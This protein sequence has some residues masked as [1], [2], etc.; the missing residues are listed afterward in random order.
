MIVFA[1]LFVVLIIRVGYLQFIRGNELRNASLSRRL[2]TQELSANRG[3]ILDTKGTVIVGNRKSYNV[4][5]VPAEYQESDDTNVENDSKKIAELTGADQ[6]KVKESLL[7]ENSYYRLI[8]KDVAKDK[9]ELLKNEGIPGIGVEIGTV[10]NYTQGSLLANVLGFVGNDNVGLEGLEATYNEQLMGEKGLLI[11]ERDR[12]GNKIPSKQHEYQ[13]AKQGNQITLTIDSE[14]QYIVEDE[15]KKLSESSINPSS[16]YVIVQNTKTGEILGMGSTPTF[17]PTDGGNADVESRKNGTVQ[18]NYEP[19]SVFKLITLSSALESGAIN[20]NTKITD[21][22]G[23]IQVLGK[24]I[25]NWDGKAIGEMDLGT[26]ASK[27]NN[28]AMV[29]IGQ[30]MGKETFY[31]YIKK[32]GFGEKTNVGLY[33]EEQ[34]IV[35]KPET[36]TALDYATTNIGQS[37]MVTPM[38][39]VNATSA[40]VNGGLLMKP[41]IVKEVRDENGKIVEQNKP[42]VLRRVISEENSKTMREIMRYV[43][44]SDGAKVANIPGYLIGGKTGTAQKVGESGGYAAGKYVTSFV[45]IAPYNDPKYAVITVVNEPSGSPVYGS[46][47]AAPTATNILKR[48]L[49]LNQEVSTDVEEENDKNDN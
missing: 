6:Q 1:T 2:Y 44:T 12:K 14:I 48:I 8:K 42:T 24:K 47:T 39:M 46:T 29:K 26:A 32:F 5:V 38:Q 16:A 17:D 10:R 18:F 15:L 31:E 7:K 13:K 36:Q 19:G 28:V 30:M 37:I 3:E 40:V 21:S 49:L 23:Y 20:K 11:I 45:G 33:G 25:K 43:V 4:Y 35:R 34:G 41:Y 9:I 27:S 22:A